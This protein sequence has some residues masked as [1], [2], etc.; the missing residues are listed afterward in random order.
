MINSLTGFKATQDALFLG[1]GFNK[2]YVSSL[3]GSSLEVGRNRQTG[4]L[5]DEKAESM[6]KLLAVCCI[7][8][9]AGFAVHAP[10]REKQAL[11]LVQTIPLPGVKGRLDHMGVDLQNKRLSSDEFSLLLVRDCRVCS[12]FAILGNGVPPNRFSGIASESRLRARRP[13]QNLIWRPAKPPYIPF[14]AAR[15][16]KFELTVTLVSRPKAR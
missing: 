3:D 14:G 13:E 1:G 8:M 2:L 6:T 11:R 4:K 16:E 12:E 5:D 10:A 7:A 9:V 15:Y